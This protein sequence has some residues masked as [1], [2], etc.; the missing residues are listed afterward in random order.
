MNPILYIIIRDDLK[1]SL[2][3]G[4]AMAQTSHASSQFVYLM[5]SS[6]LI[7]KE[8][9]KA[10]DQWLNEGNKFGT[11]IVLSCKDDIQGH[12]LINYFDDSV[13][14]IIYDAT[15]PLMFPK[16]MLNYINKEKCNLIYDINID[17]NK[18]GLI[19]ITISTETCYWLFLFKEEQIIKFKE[20]CNQINV[21]LR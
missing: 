10:F 17:E 16:E 5:Q 11:T 15:Y 3:A 1:W 14:G 2:N 7:N 4:K 8:Y 19:P 6:K 20:F 13:C 18:E 9:K 12:N 21:R